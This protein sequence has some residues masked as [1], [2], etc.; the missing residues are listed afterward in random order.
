[1]SSPSNRNR[2][3]N[4]DNDTCFET[5]CPCCPQCKCDCNCNCDCN[6]TKKKMIIPTFILSA[7]A[8]ILSI[9][10]MITK[11]TD[12]DAF[13]NFK[14]SEKT[15]LKDYEKYKYEMD[16]ILDIED[17]ENQFN[18]ALFIISIFIFFIYLILLIC[19]IYEKVCFANYNPKCK[20]PYYIIMMILN[21]IACFANAMI[22]FIFF[23]YRISQ[24]D[25]YSDYPYFDKTD[26]KDK[27]DLNIGLNI[28][29]AFCYLFCLIFHL[30]ICY[31]L[32]KEDGICSGCCSEFLNCISCCTSCLKCF[33]CCCCC[34]CDCEP[35]TPRTAYQSGQNIQRIV[36]V[37]PQN[38]IG[39]IPYNSHQMYQESSQFRNYL[40]NDLK[41]KIEQVCKT[42]I[43]DT[44]YR[45]YTTCS[46]CKNNFRDN[47]EITILP[48]GHVYHKNC[49]YNWFINNKT[50]PEDGTVVLN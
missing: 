5:Y 37:L 48:C 25:K 13:I 27:N 4:F 22:S 29:S 47:E 14:K 33:F 46:L 39:V 17:A 1:M 24:I 23:S 28:V 43:Y 9:I 30:I 21:F 49:V 40:N 31:Y 36:T 50:C 34:C 15:T 32:F 8:F 7:I 19:F 38:I 6:C 45:Q 44:N 26:F 2:H 41:L 20:V 3:R 10:E 12:T 11:V 18:L 16:E 42:A 35:K